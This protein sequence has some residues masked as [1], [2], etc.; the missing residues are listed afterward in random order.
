MQ[1]N[2]KCCEYGPC[3]L[4]EIGLKQTYMEIVSLSLELSRG[5]D[6]GEILQ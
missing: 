5:V 1:K 2:K 4:I 6:L 3:C